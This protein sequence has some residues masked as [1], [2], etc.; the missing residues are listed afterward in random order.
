MPLP[1]IAILMTIQVLVALVIAVKEKYTPE[2]II[3]Y[4]ISLQIFAVCTNL[5]FS[6]DLE[7]VKQ[8]LYILWAWSFV[9]I[10]NTKIGIRRFAYVYNRIILAVSILGCIAFIIVLLTHIEPLFTYENQD[11]RLGSF[12]YIT[13]TNARIG[14]V[15]RYSGIFDEPGAMASWGMFSLLIN[16]V[17]VKDKL[18]DRYLPIALCF[19]FSLAYYMMY[20]VYLMWFVFRKK[21]IKA[22]C[23]LFFILVIILIAYQNV[24]DET[25]IIIEKMTVNRI[26]YDESK[27]TF[28][29]NNRQELSEEAMKGFLANPV[30]GMGSTEMSEHPEMYDNP[31]ETLARY[32]LWGTFF[33]YLPLIYCMYIGLRRLDI[34]VAAVII[35]MNY[36]QRPFHVNMQHYM[37]LYLFLCVCMEAIK[38]KSNISK[39]E[40]NTDSKIDRVCSIST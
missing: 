6:G 8:I 30:F 7:Y 39:D 37:M 31:W 3:S 2:K 21:I 35:Y 29:G 23:A 16:R 22:F 9:V 28:A 1:P 11:G 10:V 18:V 36:M 33:V 12:F 5:L 17:Y 32:G 15:F 40:T 19:T 38:N 4:I 27:G 20:A 24:N 25:K 13:C 14:N 26:E 34:L